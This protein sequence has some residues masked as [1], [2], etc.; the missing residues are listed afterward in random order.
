MSVH[1]Q[2]NGHIRGHSR[3]S[4][5]LRQPLQPQ[6]VNTVQAKRSS[7][8][9]A[10]SEA[11]DSMQNGQVQPTATSDQGASAGHRHATSEADQ[12]P[13]LPAT[14]AV[15]SRP[16]GM[17]RRI[18]VGL[19][20]HLRLA[21]SNYGHAAGRK[22]KYASNSVGS[23]RYVIR[24]SHLSLANLCG[25]KWFAI[26]ELWTCVLMSLPY[27]LASATQTL[28]SS[29]HG[30]RFLDV[31]AKESLNTYTSGFWLANFV[32]LR[33]GLL[34]ASI[35]TS[36]ALLLVGLIAKFQSASPGSSKDI[37][38]IT[39]HS[40]YAQL[41]MSM[42]KGRRITGRILSVA[43]PL[44]AAV[45]LGGVRV[46]TI[47]LTTIVAN[48]M[49]IDY[50]AQTLLSFEALKRLGAC[51]RWIL[52]YVT[53]QAILDFWGVT[54]GCTSSR[55]ILSYVALITSILIF[56]PPF[57][58]SAP[59]RTTA[60]TS[61]HKPALMAPATIWETSTTAAAAAP[62]PTSVSPLIC[63]DDD[64]DLT[65]GAG[66]LTGAFSIIILLLVVLGAGA[67]PST[68]IY[69]A[70]LAGGATALSFTAVHPQHLSLSRGT[71]VLVGSLLLDLLTASVGLKSWICFA[72]QS[73]FVL[74]CF[75]ATLFDTRSSSSVSSHSR[76][77][78]L[79]HD[80]HASSLHSHHNSRLTSALL[81]I[82]EQYPLLHTILAEKDSRRIFYFMM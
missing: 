12:I 65:I 46:A 42:S 52:A 53:F 43:L 38:N 36:V 28:S 32:A 54:S 45:N 11:L 57:A 59:K 81:R 68:R 6:D 26:P 15:S 35:S 5:S 60:S 56:P 17:K 47:L 2:S 7:H 18:S 31:P 77:H 30:P 82:A 69:G 49:S 74:L 39:V 62:P 40:R 55:V 50:E 71:G 58:S 75:L 79:V 37:S 63:T 1:G 48:V 8:G 76:I 9:Y 22:P 70:I 23:A 73:V 61:I 78:V 80:H 4:M 51:R 16:K 19:P 34:L 64:I 21:G 41:T 66:L 24:S 27:F 67:I 44:Y 10:Y 29:T 13:D 3:K 25:R 14:S 33:P 72:N 20:T